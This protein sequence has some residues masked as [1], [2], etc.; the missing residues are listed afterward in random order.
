MPRKAR[1]DMAGFHHIVNR[2]IERSNVYR[3]H[4]DKEKFL[5]I[6][7]KACGVYKVNVHD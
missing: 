6:V 1:L 4:E 3:S 7:C 2:G 5:H